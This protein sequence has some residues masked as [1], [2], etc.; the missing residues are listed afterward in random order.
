MGEN[1]CARIP[2]YTLLVCTGCNMSKVSVCLGIYSLKY[3]FSE[4]QILHGAVFPGYNLSEKLVVLVKHC[5]RCRLSW[6][7]L[8]KVPIVL[9]SDCPRYL[10]PWV[11]AVQGTGCPKYKFSKVPL[12]WVQI[13]QGTYCPGYKLSRYRLS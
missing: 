3:W 13:V 6:H 2:I 4:V 11:Q 9:G 10:L 12:S 1:G 8:S 7:R 5:P